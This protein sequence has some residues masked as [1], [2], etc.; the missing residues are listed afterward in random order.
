MKTPLYLI[1][2]ILLQLFV[3]CNNKD[4]N[5]TSGICEDNLPAATI[6]GANTFGCC[7]NGN[8][9][10]PRDGTGTIGGSDDGAGLFGGYPNA[11]DYYELDIRDFKSERTAKILI[12]MHQVHINGVGDYILNQS[13]GMSS[14]DGLNHNYLH[15]RVFNN[16]T[17]S[18][19]YYRSYENSGVLKITR[20]DFT[21]RILS[22]TF[23][24]KVKNSTNPNDIIEIKNGRFDI[25]WLT[26]PNVAFP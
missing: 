2:S 7:I 25:N 18:Y 8:L 12:H 5:Y 13:N 21:S 1:F 15:C 14:I 6:N 17:N 11:T 16:A 19:Q 3:S 9:L 4:D 10:I 23:N 22:G 26:L 24:C 20:Y